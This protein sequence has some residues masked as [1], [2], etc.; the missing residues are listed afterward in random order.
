MARR[1]KDF[2][3]LSPLSLS[4]SAKDD[5]IDDFLNNPID[6]RFDVD[7]PRTPSRAVTPK[8][9]KQQPGANFDWDSQL[10]KISSKYAQRRVGTR[11]PAPPKQ[12]G[13]PDIAKREI[14]LENRTL[15]IF[16]DEEEESQPEEEETTIVFPTRKNERPNIRVDPGILKAPRST[17][18]YG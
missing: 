10:R 6:S 13:L 7:R 1:A 16:D 5:E 3:R 4:T 8:A 9:A 15:G 18:R 17:T 2:S 14:I 11:N 12:R